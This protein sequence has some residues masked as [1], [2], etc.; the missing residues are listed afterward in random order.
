[1]T[2]CQTAMRI[3]NCIRTFFG[4]QQGVS[5]VSIQGEKNRQRCMLFGSKQRFGQKHEC[6]RSRIVANEILDQSICCSQVSF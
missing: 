6:C 2:A 4:T 5:V 1:M 3:L